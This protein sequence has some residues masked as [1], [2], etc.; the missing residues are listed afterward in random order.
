[1]KF[2]PVISFL[3]FPLLCLSGKVIYPK[4][5]IDNTIKVNNNYF[6]VFRY[7]TVKKNTPDK[8]PAVLIL[9]FRFEGR[10]L[11]Q[12]RLFSLL[13]IP[14]ITG[15][16]GFEGKLWT[17]DEKNDSF[18]GVYQWES[19]EHINGYLKS[20]AYDFINKRAVKGSVTQEIL[21]GTD[22]DTF[23]QKCR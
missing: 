13:Q 8:S 16:P 14:I 17:Y 4:G 1:M 15:L 20:F 2:S 5:L 22:F 7:V 6:L 11:K 23:I 12:D 19:V 9:K 21:T 3:K 18:Q 10:T